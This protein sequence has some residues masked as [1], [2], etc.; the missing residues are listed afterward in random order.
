MLKASHRVYFM[1]EC[2]VIGCGWRGILLR[3][4]GWKWAYITEVSTGQ[5]ARLKVPVWNSLP[6]KEMEG[7]Q[8]IEP[9][10]DEETA[11]EN[12]EEK[13]DESSETDTDEPDTLLPDRRAQ[14][15][16]TE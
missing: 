9:S 7:W 1:D 16:L 15:T 10:P 3:K 2:P 8:G 14:R 5:R 6:K 13:T 12:Y 11:D 4:L